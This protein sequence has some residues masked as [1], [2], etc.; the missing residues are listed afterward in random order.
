MQS[1]HYFK[2]SVKS[3]QENYLSLPIFSLL[4]RAMA[5]ISWEELSRD[6]Q[7]LCIGRE[8]PGANFSGYKV[9]LP[10]HCL[11]ERWMKEIEIK[12][13]RIVADAYHTSTSSPSLYMLSMAERSEAK[14]FVVYF[15]RK[16]RKAAKAVQALE[17]SDDMRRFGFA[18]LAQGGL[19]ALTGDAGERGAPDL[20]HA[21]GVADHSEREIIVCKGMIRNDETNGK[22]GT[23]GGILRF[24]DDEY[25]G[26]TSAHIFFNDFDNSKGARSNASESA[27]PSPVSDSAEDFESADIVP[28][29]PACHHVF[30]VAKDVAVPL[31]RNESLGRLLTLRMRDRYLGKAFSPYELQNI[32]LERLYNPSQDWA[33]FR[34][35]DPRLQHSNEIKIGPN[36]PINPVPGYLGNDPPSDE[37]WVISGPCGI[38]EASGLGMKS[39]I[40]LPWSAEYV[41]AWPIA[42][43]L[44]K[45]T[46]EGG[47]LIY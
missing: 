27:S 1:E 39:S 6:D 16:L 3:W 30:S 8:V 35:E 40:T 22:R 2:W 20:G 47:K 18:Y 14:P 10:A 31:E 34:V 44:G 28:E 24:G 46:R 45:R 26:M 25:Y 19:Q 32:G 36:A 33:L 23:I 5:Y 42:C 17:D 29:V 13:R 4:L 9:W 15:D 38:V 43:E 11:K 41:D 37:L 7:L 12:V 21:T